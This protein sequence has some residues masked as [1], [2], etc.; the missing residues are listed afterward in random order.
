MNHKYI[1]LLS[2]YSN[3]YYHHRGIRS[4]ET[5]ESVIN[6]LPLQLGQLVLN[7]FYLIENENESTGRF[8]GNGIHSSLKKKY[9][10]YSHIN[11]NIM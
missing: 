4:G 5:V 9:V 1:L 11:C 3:P 10:R 6:I 7:G 8:P 2:H